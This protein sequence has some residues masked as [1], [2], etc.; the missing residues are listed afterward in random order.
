MTQAAVGTGEQTTLRCVMQIDIVGIGDAEFDLAERVAIAE[1]AGLLRKQIVIDPGLG[2]GKD[3]AQN[4]QLLEGFDALAGLGLPILIGASR[5]RFVAARVAQSSG[6]DPAQVTLE[7]RDEATAD[8]SQKLW[9]QALDGQNA[10]RLWGF[11]VHNV[12]ANL[13]ALRAA[14]ALRFAD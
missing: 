7:Q 2:F 8:L 5:K 1:A 4:W 14:A 11:R 3:S 9:N 13:D 10:N 12:Q 6:I